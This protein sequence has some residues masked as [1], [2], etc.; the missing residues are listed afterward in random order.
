MRPMVPLGETKPAMSALTVA[1]KSARRGRANNDSAPTTRL[2]NWYD[3]TRAISATQIIA[4]QQRKSTC[5]RAN[6]DVNQLS[7]PPWRE[8]V[9]DRC[10]LNE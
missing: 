2:P 7:T 8:H 5:N 6:H 4:V 9:P 3:H 10:V 1:D